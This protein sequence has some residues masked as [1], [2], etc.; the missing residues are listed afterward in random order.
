[1]KLQVTGY[2]AIILHNDLIRMENVSTSF[3]ENGVLTLVGGSV[4]I[5]TPKFDNHVAS[6]SEYGTTL[7]QNCRGP[8]RISTVVVTGSA[9]VAITGQSRVKSDLF[10]ADIRDSGVLYLAPLTKLKRA[11]FSISGK[12]EV[13]GCIVESLFLRIC[14]CGK[15]SG[16]HSIRNARFILS[17]YAIVQCKRTVGCSLVKTIT[18]G[19]SVSVSVSLA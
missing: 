11:R 13:W 10:C 7:L 17:N 4:A 19:H 12:G 18:D 16:F 14:D 3:L 5:P 1:M 2:A 15:T 8:G 9:R 6:I